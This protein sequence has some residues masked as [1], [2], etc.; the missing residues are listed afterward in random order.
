ML[1]QP[2][3]SYH[4]GGGWYV[5]STDSVWTINW[6][7][8]SPTTIPVSFGFGRVWKAD[9]QTLD[10]W[11]SGEWMAYRQYSTITPMYTVRFGLNFVFP[12][13]VLGR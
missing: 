9:E 1:F 8:N 4:L 3:F 11:V 2:G 5:K 6:R 10:M 12:E 13:F 7:H